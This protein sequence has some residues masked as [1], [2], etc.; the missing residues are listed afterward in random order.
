M[1]KNINTTKYYRLA[2]GRVIKVEPSKPEVRTPVTEADYEA[3]M[4]AQ[5]N[6]PPREPRLVA[7]ER[8]KSKDGKGWLGFRP[9][10]SAEELKANYIKVSE[11]EWNEHLRSMHHEPSAAELALR[12]KKK[13]IAVHK[14]FLVDTDWVIVKISEEVE[15]DAKAA[16]REKYADVIAERKAAR[17]AINELEESL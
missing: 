12:E 8:Y 17:E 5:A 9:D 1:S 4:A 7:P 15:E 6:K 13:Q 11:Q 10:I 16:L 2:D 14:K 3:Y